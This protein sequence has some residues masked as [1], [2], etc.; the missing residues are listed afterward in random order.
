M[1]KRG[2]TVV[3]VLIVLVLIVAVFFVFMQSY[4]SGDSQTNTK[5]AKKVAAS[6]SSD[7][8]EWRKKASNDFLPPQDF[9]RAQEG[10]CA[11]FY[12]WP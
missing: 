6:E 2:A 12:S 9:G 11:R 5:A 10:E 1:K 3:Y 4:D 8:P 7:N